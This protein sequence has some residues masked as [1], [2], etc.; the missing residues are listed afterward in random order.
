MSRLNEEEL[1]LQC[2]VEEK[3]RTLANLELNGTSLTYSES[4][5]L[6][7]DIATL[8]TKRDGLSFRKASD[9]VTVRLCGEAI[10]GCSGQIKDLHCALRTSTESNLRTKSR[11]S[12]LE[13]VLLSMR[14]Q[15]NRM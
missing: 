13:S 5:A 9:E 1:P 14:E 15:L 7:K 2:I 6:H 8:T 10:A 4:V 3:S 12:S 11:V